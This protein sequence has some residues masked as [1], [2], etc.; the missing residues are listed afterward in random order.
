MNILKNAA[1]NYR[2]TIGVLIGWIIGVFTNVI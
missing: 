1:I 2:L